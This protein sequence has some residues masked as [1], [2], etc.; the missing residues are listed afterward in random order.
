MKTLPN[1]L[2]QRFIEL[3]NDIETAIRLD[4]RANIIERV[5]RNMTGPV[6]GKFGES[7]AI[8]IA[9]GMHGEPLAG[10]SHPAAGRVVP[11]TKSH[12]RMLK[13]LEQGFC[14]VPTLAG[15][16]NIKKQT[17]YDYLQHIKKHGYELETR[18][19]GNGRGSYYKI[20][21]LARSA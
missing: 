2:I 9:T 15:N 3:T 7:V 16:L 17:V 14:A 4:E 13:Y 20:Y 21:R 8:G 6:T 10:N 5:N 1:H 19:T 12:R 11:L 18:N